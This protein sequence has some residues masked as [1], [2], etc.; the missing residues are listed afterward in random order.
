MTTRLSYTESPSWV[1]PESTRPFAES[2]T[3]TWYHREPY[4]GPNGDLFYRGAAVTGDFATRTLQPHR[5]L[6]EP[7]S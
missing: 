2:I 1:V 5:R 3:S 7:T 6:D 4:P